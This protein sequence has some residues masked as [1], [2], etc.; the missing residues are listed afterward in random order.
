[1]P[2][3]LTPLR[4][5]PRPSPLAPRGFTFIEVLFSV[6]ILGVGLIMIAGMLPVA[7]KQNA[8]TRNDLTAKVVCDSGYAFI[9]TLIQQHPEAFPETCGDRGSAAF[10]GIP[11]FNGGEPFTPKA[12]TMLDEFMG[13]QLMKLNTADDYTPVGSNPPAD[14]NYTAVDPATGVNKSRTQWGRFRAGRMM[15]LSYDVVYPAGTGTN[16]GYDIGNLVANHTF[17]VNKPVGVPTRLPETDT[18]PLGWH[19]VVL[20]DRIVSSEPRFQWLAFYRRDEGSKVI[21]LVIVAMR[22]QTSEVTDRYE[23]GKTLPNEKIGDPSTPSGTAIGNGPFLVPVEIE[24]SL[25]GPDVVK[26]LGTPG[27]DAWDV[28]VAETG[29]FLIVAHSPPLN[30]N[31]NQSATAGDLNRPFRN[32]G[33]IFRLAARRDDLDT[34]NVNRV[35][36]LAPGFDL[37]S[38]DAGPDQIFGTP[39]DVPDGSMNVTTTLTDN[40][41]AIRSARAHQYPVTDPNGNGAKYVDGTRAYAWIIGRGHLDPTTGSGAYVGATQDLGVLSVDLPIP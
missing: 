26:F 40:S 2:V 6:V 28:D 38:A 1:M 15:P 23:I 9:R 33:K 4:L 12:N 13:D 8:D 5:A 31:D 27:T 37:D 14:P 20:G 41:V 3:P 17:N 16:G 36:E 29:S 34:P 24:D 25:T 18:Y 30:G 32:N 11:N 35:W 10:N 7:I 22:Q 21:K 19:Q 39:D